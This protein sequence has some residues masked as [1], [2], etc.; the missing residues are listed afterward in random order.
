MERLLN[1]HPMAHTGSIG[2]SWSDFLAFT[3]ATGLL[4]QRVT[5]W[6]RLPERQVWS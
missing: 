4:H 3:H 5:G 1:F 2:L 6:V